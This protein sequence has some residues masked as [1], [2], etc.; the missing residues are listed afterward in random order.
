MHDEHVFGH[1]VDS[2]QD[3][4]LKEINKVP[5]PLSTLL[6]A[7]PLL[8]SPARYNPSFL[9]SPLLPLSHLTMFPCS[10]LPRRMHR[11]FLTI[12]PPRSLI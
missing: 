4:D 1:I 5:P 11:I 3:L 2:V 7:P 9:S 8:P 10:P 12:T 6:L